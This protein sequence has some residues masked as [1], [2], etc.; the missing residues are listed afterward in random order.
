MNK[1]SPD[2]TV[3]VSVVIPCYNDGAFLKGAIQSVLKSIY[4]GFEMIITNDGS[5]DSITLEVLREIEEEFRHDQDRH[6]RIIH[7]DNLGLAH[8]RNN[9]IRVASGEYILP[10]DADN[11]IRPHYLGNAVE[12]LDK[13]PEI[14]VVYAYAQCFGEDEKLWEFPVFSPRRLLLGNFVEA[15]SIFRKRIWEECNGYDPDMGIM[16]YEDW[17][18]WIGAMKHGWKFHLIK[19]VMFDYH[20]HQ[21]S[22]I[23]G[24]NIPEN[25]RYLTRYICNKYRG[26]YVE[27]LDYV[28]SEK[29]VEILRLTNL[30][31]NFEELIQNIYNSRGWKVLLICYKIRDWIIPVNSIRRDIV[32]ILFNALKNPKDASSRRNLITK[33]KRKII[34][35]F[36]SQNSYKAW[37]KKHEPSEAD[38]KR[39]QI[40]ANS[41]KYQPKI[42]IITPVYNTGKNLLVGMIESVLSQ[43]YPNWELCIAEGGSSLT[44]V[45]EILKE[46]SQKDGRVK[47]KFMSE[48]KGI[49]R[50]S[51][52]ALTLSTGEFVGFLDHDDKL[53]PHSLYEVV[54]LLNKSPEI[55]LL[56]SDEDKISMKGKRFEPHFKPDWSPDTLL[57]HNYICHFTVIKK[58]I[59]DAV[60]GFRDGYEGSQDYDLF[61]RVVEKTQRIA[62]IPKILYH[63][64]WH[65]TSTSGNPKAKMYAYESAKKALKDHIQRMGLSGEVLDG[66]F[67][68]SYRIKYHIE[69]SPGV[70]IIILSKDKA[71]VLKRCINSILHLSSYRNYKIFIVD[72]QSREGE[73]FRYYE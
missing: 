69:G 7:Q 14:G 39:F 42:S 53:A 44:H 15:C 46:Y 12:I 41:L 24:C 48:N 30:L 3:K 9:A 43:I 32:K 50:N 35:L 25:H 38:L 59:V 61:L 40:E 29:N 23:S 60:G 45:Q 4:E 58:K 64:S 21:G 55:D 65:E 36:N 16:G 10:L 28:I 70:S 73:T 19:E 51:N 34:S 1:K 67:L 72:N 17:D 52:E 57:S 49:A 18:L 5:T 20:V 31:R 54:R 27:N 37:I 2:N 11:R 6:V 47:V 13:Q 71:D 66:N 56:Y 22:M 8:A 33:I 62:H 63:W 26:I 68:S